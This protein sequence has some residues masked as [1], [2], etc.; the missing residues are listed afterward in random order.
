MKELT[1]QQLDRA[2]NRA[3]Q[4]MVN[5]VETDYSLITLW[6]TDTRFEA[7]KM[8]LTSLRSETAAGYRR[9]TFRGDQAQVDS[10]IQAVLGTL[11]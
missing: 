4:G 11:L 8:Y 1:V 6:H 3:T 10:Y 2:R 5:I 9:T 7:A